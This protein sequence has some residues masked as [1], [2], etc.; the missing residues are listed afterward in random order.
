MTKDQVIHIISL[1]TPLVSREEI[2]EVKERLNAPKA[3]AFNAGEAMTHTLQGLLRELPREHAVAIATEFGRQ[4][5]VYSSNLEELQAHLGNYASMQQTNKV[6]VKRLQAVQELLDERKENAR[7]EYQEATT[8][9][10]QEA[11][12][13][14][15]MMELQLIELAL[16]PAQP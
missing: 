1:L 16:N 4:H 2:E 9:S 7:I 14:A 5:A 13:A 12:V 11:V 6:L 15:R 10:E 3:T 8:D